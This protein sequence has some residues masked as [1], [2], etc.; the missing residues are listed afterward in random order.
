M[1]LSEGLI[2]YCCCSECLMKFRFDQAEGSVFSLIYYIDLVGLRIAEYEEIM[3]EQLHLDA[4]VLGE[5]GF[6]SELL[7]THDPDLAVFF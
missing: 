2:I 6:D 7:G 4:G 3:S 5:H 1:N